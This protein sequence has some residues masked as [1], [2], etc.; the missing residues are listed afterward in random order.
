MTAPDYETGQK[1][2]AREENVRLYRAL[3]GLRSIPKNK[4]YWTLSS[5]QTTDPE[6]EINQMVGMGLLT[7]DQ[8]W[9]VDRDQELVSLNRQNHPDAHF[10]DAGDWEDVIL[11][12]EDFNPAMVYLDTLNEAGRLS[13]NLTAFTMP[14]CSA[15]TVLLV[16]VA[17]SSRY[18]EVA[19]SD[20]FIAG[21]RKRVP[22]LLRDWTIHE[23]CFEYCGRTTRM[24]TYAFYRKAK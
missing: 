5:L 24:R 21:L 16:N 20:K 9:G 6:S 12:Q 14:L 17:Q 11:G 18:R 22:D 13:L 1:I 2:K 23:D 3:S 7:K 8:F 19:E 15:G 4:Q 10:P